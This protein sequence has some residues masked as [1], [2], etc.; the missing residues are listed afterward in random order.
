LLCDTK[1]LTKEDKYIALSHQWGPPL[2]DGESDPLAKKTV[3]TFKHN[4]KKIEKE[5]IDNSGFPPKYLDAITIA[6]ELDIRYLWIDSL[7]IIQRDWSDPTDEGEDWKKEAKNMEHVFRCAYVTIAAS[8][9]RSSAEHFLKQRPE[10]HCVTMQKDSAFYYLCDVID[11]F[12]RDV[13]QGELNSRGWVFQERALSRRTIHFTTKQTY[14]ECGEGV[15]CE[16][17]TKTKKYVISK[18]TKKLL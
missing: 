4:I 12:D 16:T 18:R 1:S 11:D 8:C 15:R 14:W 13:E 5:G 10:R 3:R 6:R 9:V 2:K 7:C 17:L